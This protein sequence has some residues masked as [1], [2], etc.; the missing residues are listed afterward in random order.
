MKPF[1]LAIGLCMLT[2]ETLLAADVADN[3]TTAFFK[4]YLDED[5]KRHPVEASR[6]GDY[7]YADRMNDLSPKARAMIEE[8]KKTNTYA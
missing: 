3:P 2:T 7:R 8:F 6:L 4:K 5:A 1:A